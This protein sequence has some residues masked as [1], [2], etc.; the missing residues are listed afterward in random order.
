ML[1]GLERAQWAKLLFGTISTQAQISL[2]GM[3]AA[4]LLKVIGQCHYIDNF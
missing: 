4:I 1:T 3:K 2:L